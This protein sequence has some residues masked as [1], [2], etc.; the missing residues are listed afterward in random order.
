MVLIVRIAFIM[1]VLIVYIVFTGVKVSLGLT[2]F[3]GL[4]PGLYE[5]G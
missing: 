3:I 2:V 4:R 1:I 5:W